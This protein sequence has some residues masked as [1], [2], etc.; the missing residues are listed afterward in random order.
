MTQMYHQAD[1]NPS[2]LEGKTIA[3]LGYGSQGRGQSL[4]LRDSGANVVIGLRPGG[5][6]WQQAEQEG[7]QPVGFTDAVRD[8]D[9]VMMLT[10]DMVQAEIYSEHVEPNIKPGAMLM[11][12]HGLN[13]I[14]DLIKPS[15]E[16]D[17][18][19]VAPKGPGF[20]V[21]TE[22]EKGAGVPC[23]MAVHQDAS[24]NAHAK[25]LAYADAIGG[26][27]GGVLTTNF[28]EETETDLFGEQAVLCGGAISLVQAGWETLTEAG[29]QPE[30]AYFECLHELKLIVDLLYE[31]GVSRMHEFVSDTAAYGAVTRGPR[32]V[33]GRAKEEMKKVLAE[34]QSGEFAREWIAE[35][36]SGSENYR[37]LQ[38]ADCDHPIE[39]VGA[40]LRARMP[41][42]NRGE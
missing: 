36:K 22:Y 25:A 28:K 27:R 10:P 7:W 3:V 13:I 41:W 37:R 4:N 32:V 24:G 18:T 33:D 16:I 23:L 14:Y 35:H 6:S 40:D 12:S 15:A 29:Y 39:A 42:L 30:L 19:M 17:V 34:I 8:A 38:K 11:F 1:A 20:L 26:T 9:I 21:R 2:L 5:A 31:G